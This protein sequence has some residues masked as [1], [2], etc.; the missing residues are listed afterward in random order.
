MKPNHRAETFIMPNNNPQGHNQYTKRGASSAP[1]GH[2]D[3]RESSRRQVA[4][5]EPERPGQIGRNAGDS[6]EQDGQ[7]R[8]S[9]ESRAPTR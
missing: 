9:R 2:G 5:V 4:A 7:G 6:R 8:H 3:S 1:R